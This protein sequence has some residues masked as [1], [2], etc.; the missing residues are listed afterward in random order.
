MTPEQRASR[1]AE[2][3]GL[4]AAKEEEIK[5]LEREARASSALVTGIRVEKLGE[6]CSS[7]KPARPLAP[8]EFR[9]PTEM[10][11]TGDGWKVI[12]TLGVWR[13]AFGATPRAALEGLRQQVDHY[14]PKG[15]DVSWVLLDP[16]AV[17]AEVVYGDAIA[18]RTEGLNVEMEDGCWSA[19]L[20]A[21]AGRRNRSDDLDPITI[22][23]ASD[24]EAAVAQLRAALAESHPFVA[25]V[26][27]PSERMY[28]RHEPQS[29]EAA[30]VDYDA[31]R[32]EAT[33]QASAERAI[34]A[35]T[36]L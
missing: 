16:D 29:H 22:T 8:V 2:L 23:W 26:G 5:A 3:K 35:R 6:Q 18:A 7:S 12:T 31:W 33:G 24:A 36:G 14:A 4:L 9:I 28:F 30:T 13:S 25:I 17:G 11:F 1:L 21:Q 27:E 19:L 15:A 10:K 32:A 20:P 34:R